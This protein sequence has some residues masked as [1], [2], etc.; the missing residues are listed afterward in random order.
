MTFPPFLYW[1][2]TIGARILFACWLWLFLSNRPCWC[3]VFK[4]Q[5][6]FSGMWRPAKVQKCHVTG[7]HIQQMGA[8]REV[9]DCL[10]FFLSARC[11][12]HAGLECPANLTKRDFLP[13]IEKDAAMPIRYMET[14]TLLSVIVVTMTLV[15]ISMNV[16]ECVWTSKSAGYA[17]TISLPSSFSPSPTSFA[18]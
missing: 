13:L 14:S 9:Q 17:N 11:F 1:W 12:G 18:G 7:L 8:H 5:V 15:N 4:D 3:V 10:L 16:Y 2:C 6:S